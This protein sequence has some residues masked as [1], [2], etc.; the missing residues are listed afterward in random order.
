MIAVD[1]NVLVRLLVGDNAAHATKAKKI[2]DNAA[3]EAFVV[4]VSDSVL[5][6]LVWTLSRAYARDRAEI[7]MALR[8]LL[9][10]ASVALE[11]VSA[12]MEATAL[13]EIGPADFADCLLSVKAKNAGC[14][15]LMTFDRGM[16]NL[17]GV[18]LL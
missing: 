9:S 16:K 15:N 14:T 18:K 17:P 7:V 13:F 10:H 3:S 5:V 6:E 11:S 1:T 12:A 8:A 2:F 4:W